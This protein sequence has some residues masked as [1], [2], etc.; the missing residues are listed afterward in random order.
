MELQVSH[1]FAVRPDWGRVWHE[2][3]VCLSDQRLPRE[4][5]LLL[6]P[7]AQ[8]AQTNWQFYRPNLY[9]SRRWYTTQ[10]EAWTLHLHR[11][12]RFND[13]IWNSNSHSNSQA[14]I[15]HMQAVMVPLAIYGHQWD[16][17]T[18]RQLEEC[19]QSGPRPDTILYKQH[20]FRL[21]RNWKP[22]NTGIDDGHRRGDWWDIRCWEIQI[23]CCCV[24]SFHH[25]SEQ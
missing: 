3:E 5:L 24:P 4:E 7:W 15:W 8:H 10:S 13:K 17:S 2:D 23:Q 22:L 16:I 21:G 11:S 25:H 20:A 14:W 12:N 18:A 19:E 6:D 1:D 9:S